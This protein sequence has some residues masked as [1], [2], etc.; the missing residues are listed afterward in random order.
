MAKD[1]QESRLGSLGV[2]PFSAPIAG[3]SLTL[4]QGG[5]RY[6]APAQFSTPEA[7]SEYV[8]DQIVKPRNAARIITMLKAGLTCEAM[9]RTMLFAGFQNAKWTVDTALLIGR[10]VLYM[11]VALANRAKSNGLIGE[12]T[13][14]SPDQEQNDFMGK[15]MA[16]EK[17]ITAKVDSSEAKALEKKIT[18]EPLDI[19]M[20]KGP[21]MGA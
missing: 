21:M 19:E 8:F 18:K 13:I 1:K 16:L 7:A 11:I 10:P 20:P 2:D 6:E 15:F 5:S 17:K 12:F 9:A 14:M 4:P 3:H